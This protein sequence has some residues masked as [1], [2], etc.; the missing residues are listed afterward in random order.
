MPVLTFGSLFAGI[1]GI[2]LGLERA[3]MQVRWQVEID[4]FC[5][6]VLE[7]HWPDIPRYLDVRSVGVLNAEPVD[8][9]AGGFPCQP[10]SIA[11]KKLAQ[12]DERWLWP[13]MARIIRELRPGYVLLE[14]VPGLL[15][16]GFGDVLGDLAACGY[17]AE[18][19]CL[20][21]SDLG[22]PHRRERVFVVAYPNG[23]RLEGLWSQVVR[24]AQRYA[25]DRP[26]WH[27]E[28]A[29]D[30]VADGFPDRVDRMRA[31]GNAVVPQVVEAIGRVIASE[32]AP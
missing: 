27:P 18:W 31:L 15:A 21:A 1:G 20:R 5:N 22:A 29:L 7:K 12:A 13:E 26:W 2:D 11:G 6:R 30:R 32:H 3:G 4:E 24:E 17:D 16:R 8:V 28:P 19:D 14:N 10:V 25:A 9:I 23:T